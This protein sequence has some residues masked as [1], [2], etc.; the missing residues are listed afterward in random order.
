MVEREEE[1]LRALEIDG[2]VRAAQRLRERQRAP[3]HDVD[4]DPAAALAQ[5]GLDRL[6]EATAQ[7]LL[8]D[9]AIEDHGDVRGRQLSGRCGE[10]DHFAVHPHPREATAGQ[11]GPQLREGG[12]RRD[13]KPKGDEGARAGVGGQEGVDDAL[14]GVGDRGRSARGRCRR[15]TLA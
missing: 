7:A 9:H 8:E 14:R 2:A 12:P 6:R 15:P 10:I 13:V 3:A 1:W 11:R 5:A 4:L